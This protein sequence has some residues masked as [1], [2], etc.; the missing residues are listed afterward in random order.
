MFR[1]LPKVLHKLQIDLQH[2]KDNNH[3]HQLLI[4]RFYNKLVSEITICVKANN[5][6]SKEESIGQ[7]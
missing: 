2:I 7:S 5:D 4:V 3:I 1:L 6:V